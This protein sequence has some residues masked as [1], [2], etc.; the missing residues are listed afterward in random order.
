MLSWWVM[1][2][3]AV[4]GAVFLTG[5]ICLSLGFWMCSWRLPVGA[6]VVVMTGFF[7]L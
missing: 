1:Q 7:H 2:P 4:E 6:C 3:E 5:N